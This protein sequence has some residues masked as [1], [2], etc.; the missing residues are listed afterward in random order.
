MRATLRSKATFIGVGLHTG[1]KV[2]MTVNPASAQ[3]GIWFRRTDIELGD[4]MVPAIYTAVDEKPLCTRLINDD[5][6]EVG[7]VEH[8]MA[9]LSGCGI[10]NALIE[11]NGPE[12]PILDGCAATFVRAFIAKGI[13]HQHV[14]Q[15]A[16][17]IL[18]PVIV[19][20]GEAMA[21]LTPAGSLEIDFQIEFADRAIGKQQRLLNMAN[22]TFVRELADS[23]TF[24]RKSDIDTMHAAGLALGGTYENAVVVDDD[25]V[26]SPG[27]LRH[28]DE[29][30]RHKMLDALGDLALAGMP[31]LGRYSGVKAGH[32]MTNRL[33][34]KLF[35]T[36]GAYRVVACTSE[37][38]AS[39]PGT[40]VKHEDLA[41]VA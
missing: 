27:G 22:G 8:I 38:L 35:A 4:P 24:C 25:D 39:L 7:T 30:V 40:G 6:V 17:E 37:Q 33:L 41:L 23:R 2:T 16:I 19:Q 3:Y 13:R 26:L 28:A 15:H 31:I 14:D 20:D 1:E 18:K 11:I 32:A 36:P 12:V 5:G 21:M 34:R 10:H 29:A 9:A